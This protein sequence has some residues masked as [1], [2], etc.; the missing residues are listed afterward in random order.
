MGQRPKTGG[1]DRAAVLPVKARTWLPAALILAVLY[2]ALA[3]GSLRLFATLNAS[4]S[5]V[6]PPTG[7]AIAALLLFGRRLWPGVLVGAFAANLLTSGRPD[8]AL[9]I[10]AGN[11]LEAVAAAS[12][13]ARYARGPAAF[14]TIAGLATFVVASL[15]A[16]LLGALVGTATLAAAGLLAPGDVTAALATWWF[17]DAAGALV[18]APAILLLARRP[19]E[20]MGRPWEVALLLAGAAVAGWLVFSDTLFGDLDGNGHAPLSFL[21]MPLV[22]WTA[23]RLGSREG[24]LST[25]AIGALAV[26]GTLRGQGPFA[27][28]PT[29]E[30]LLFLQLFLMV[31]ST[32]GLALGALVRERREAER[33]MA[34]ARAAEEQVR[35]VIESAG[36][37]VL[38][39]DETGAI[40]V[41]NAQ[42]ERLFGYTRQ[43]L[44][45]LKVEHLMPG[46]FHDTHVHHRAQYHAAPHARQM[47]VGLELRALRK[48]GTEFPVEIALG[49]LSPDG[50][51]WVVATVRD[52]S[53][54]KRSEAE[55]D[56]SRRQLAVTEKLSALG[57]LVSGVG[58]EIRTPLTYI[59]TNLALIR[60]QVEKAAQGK[61]DLQPTAEAVGRYVQKSQEGVQRVERIV[62]QLRSFAKAEVR[63]EVCDLREAAAGAIE[64][65]TATHKGECRVEADLAPA[66][67][68]EVDKGQVQQVLLN[69]LNNA[70]EAMNRQGRIA[71][72]LRVAGDAAEIEVQDEGPGI[73]ADVQARIFDPFYTTKAQGTG[74]GLSISRRILE[75]HGGSIRFAT[76]PK[77]TTFTVRLPRRRPGGAPA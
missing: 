33:R 46:R 65:W 60:M 11:T 50:E 26:W 66:P 72:R 51:R 56:A 30:A 7:L 73:P 8:V 22:V 4:T 64:L 52:V 43:E 41:V 2:T 48:D 68:F 23:A 44:L 47:G 21:V 13:V 61:P 55:L 24:T 17:G 59:V 20:P 16:S 67:G 53:E 5:P 76:S 63:M 54:R 3:W 57:T 15:A 37:A 39:A 70:G 49:P 9:A 25:L 42:A 35:A 36:D 34:A 58:H 75:A 27:D 28:I 1:A 62:T 6:W 74:L 77:G 71:V 10:A 18:V 29:N 38:I 40:R 19:P 69:L 12:A 14:D 32:T 31:V 45:A